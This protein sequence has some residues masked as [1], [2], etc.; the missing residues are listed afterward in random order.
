M[1]LQSI[2]VVRPDEIKA[3]VEQVNAARDPKLSALDDAEKVGHSP[4]GMK[5]ATR[6]LYSDADS[7]WTNKYPYYLEEP[8]ENTETSQYALLIR[9]EKSNDGRRKLKMHSI[10][11]QSPLLK[12]ALGSVLLG[13]PGVT[14]ELDRLEFEAPFEPF[15]HRWQRLEDVKLQEDDLETKEH[16]DLFWEILEAEI[17]E[18]IKTSKNLVAHGVITYSHLWT[19]FEPGSLI[20]TKTDGHERVIKLKVG[21]YGYGGQSFCV[22]YQYVDWDGEN[23]GT[24]EKFLEIAK[25]PGTGAITALVA[26]PILYHPNREDVEQRCIAR[27]VIFESLK[28]FQYRSYKGIGISEVNSYK[29]VKYHIDGRIII[30]TSAFNLFNPNIDIAVTY[31]TDDKMYV[32]ANLDLRP[33]ENQTSLSTNHLLITTPFVRGYAL[34]EKKWLR[35]WIEKVLAITWNDQ[36]F[37]SLVLPSNTKDLLLAFAESQ[38]KRDQI[39]DDVIRGKGKGTI[40]LLSGPPGV[41]K[42]LTAESVAEKIRVPLYMMS[43]GE[44]GTSHTEVEAALVNVLNMTTKWR[45][46]LLIDEADV[47]LEQRSPSGNLDRNKL[48]SIFL[49]LLEYYE[50][51]LFLTSNR[52][53]HIDP[54][55]ESRIHLSLQY[56]ELSATSRRQVWE[57]FL[58][59]GDKA[60]DGGRFSEAQMATLLKIPLNGRQ[61]KNIIKTAQ[62]LA[63]SKDVPLGFEHVQLVTNLRAANACIPLA[64]SK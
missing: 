43:A 63:T 7:G 32:P 47:F 28:G 1:S 62:L 48:V 20:F 8:A 44:L 29:T 45:A 3:L 14:A 9:Y 23:F 21:R 37:A 59:Q 26:Y 61:I 57:T 52:V 6:N 53:E 33:V 30:D 55:F 25:Y 31:L 13:Y 39:F 50:G 11:I 16:L 56:D 58:Y 60:S 35:F 4:L 38:V 2:N 42:T 46:V 51:F 5:C 64:M 12:K 15:V 49:R 17:G 41:G 18:T 36:A 10:V 19:I 54:A 27:G 34:K 24:V 40:M 22:C